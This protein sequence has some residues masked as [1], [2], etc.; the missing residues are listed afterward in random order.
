MDE[1]ILEY[2]RALGVLGRAVDLAKVGAPI[3][4]IGTGPYWRPRRALEKLDVPP[5]AA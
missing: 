5:P 3:A 2:R 4:V 1:A